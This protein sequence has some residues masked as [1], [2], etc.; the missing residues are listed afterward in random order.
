MRIKF[1][2]VRGSV[3]SPLTLVQVEEK[4]RDVM[5][6][7]S[8]RVIYGA[9]GPEGVE[10]FL[11]ELPFYKRGTYG[12]NTSCVEVMCCGDERLILDM[13]TGLR[14]LGNSLMKEMFE[15][16]GIKVNFLLSHMHWDHIRGLP[17]YSPLYINR[18]LGIENH[19]IFYGGTDWQRKAEI[20]LQGQMDPPNFPVSWAEI[21]K[22]THRIE[23]NG[24]YDKMQIGR[25]RSNFMTRKL[26]HPQETYG[27]RVVEHGSG[28]VLAYTTDNEPYDPLE[29]D[30]RLLELA[31]G[32][33]VWITDCQ[34]TQDQYNGKENAGG[35]PR[36]GWGHSYDIA[37]AKT[38]VMAKVK[39]VVLFHHD[40]ASDDKKIWEMEQKVKHLIRE[41]GGASTVIAAHEG[42]ELNL[43]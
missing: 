31:Q 19:W 15:N 20:C 27:Y 38:A 13:G 42:L 25:L 1:W 10:E 39:T 23:F 9:I 30:P 35:V 40:P 16:M 41:M 43:E 33:D 24:I 2:G 28:V 5:L 7:H 3:P 8:E 22:M 32:A 29:P 6:A 26:N 17:F 18:E 21:C 4:L 37:V 34:Y 11:Q 36:H 14:E 12:G